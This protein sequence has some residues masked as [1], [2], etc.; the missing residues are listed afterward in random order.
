VLSGLDETSKIAGRLVLLTALAPYQVDERVV[1]AFIERFPGHDRLLNAL[2]W[3]SLTAARK[4]GT[5]LYVPGK[6]A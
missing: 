1:R 6:A 2:A 3:G 5:W 4:I